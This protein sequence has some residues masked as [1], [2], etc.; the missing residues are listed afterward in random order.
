MEILI[1][2]YAVIGVWMFIHDNYQN[3]FQRVIVECG[4]KSFGD[5]FAES[6]NSLINDT[7]LQNPKISFL[8][9]IVSA[10]IWP[11]T[12][13]TLAVLRVIASRY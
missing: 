9:R 10:A 8:G 4:R 13:L 5:E 12:L 11:L 7:R 2:I 3:Q 1:I 6:M